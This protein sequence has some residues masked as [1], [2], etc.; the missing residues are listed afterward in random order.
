MAKSKSNA[1]EPQKSE[2]A[3]KVDVE[4]LKPLFP[5][6]NEVGDKVKIEATP[7]RLDYLRKQG[8]IK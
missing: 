7:T 2:T 5:Y 3:K 1:E 6:A 4:L 8:F